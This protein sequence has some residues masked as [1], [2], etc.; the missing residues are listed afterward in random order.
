VQDSSLFLLRCRAVEGR[1]AH[2]SP[3]PVYR[4]EDPGKEDQALL[5]LEFP[6]KIRKGEAG[7]DSEEPLAREN[8]H[9]DARD[10]QKNTQS[11]LDGRKREKNNRG[12]SSLALGIPLSAGEIVGGDSRQNERQGDEGAEKRSEGEKPEADEQN[13]MLIVYE[14]KGFY[15]FSA[16]YRIET[17]LPARNENAALRAAFSFRNRGSGAYGHS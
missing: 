1:A 3:D 4:A 7:H 11:V 14:L 6:R 12:F 5:Q 8:Q 10:H 17:F 15:H 9:E 13:C 16:G 2:A